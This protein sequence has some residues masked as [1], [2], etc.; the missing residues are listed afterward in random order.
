MPKMKSRSRVTPE[1]HEQAG[2]VE[3]FRGRFPGVVIFAIPNGGKR[4]IATARKLKQEGVVAGVPDLFVPAWNLWIE[5]KRVK[6]GRVSD[7]QRDMIEYLSSVG[8]T[9][10]IGYGA[11]DASRKILNFIGSKQ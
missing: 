9:C 6:G 5:M 10:I 3:W 11:E 1:F 4:S 2:L 8:H 7:V